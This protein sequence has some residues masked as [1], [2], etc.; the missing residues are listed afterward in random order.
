MASTPP[1][2]APQDT[3]PFVQARAKWDIRLN[4]RDLIDQKRYPNGNPRVISLRLTEKLGEEADELEIVI[5]DMLASE[6]IDPPP[7][8]S[9]LTVAIGWDRGSLVSTGMV[10]KGSFTV[11][12][13]SWGGPPDQITIT[14]RSAD[15]KDSFR[16]RKTRTWHDQTLGGVIGQLAADNALQPRCHPDL[17]GKP[18]TAAEQHN[19]SDMQFLR[20]LGRH[21]D[22]VATVKAGCLI[23]APRGAVTTASGKEIPGAVLFRSRCANV[24]WRRASRDKDQDGAEAQWHDS[25]AGKRKTVAKGGT[26]KKRLKRIYASEDDAS[27]A[28]QSE[29]N[30]QKR[31]SATLEATLAW[32]NPLLTPGMPIEAVGFRA[33]IDAQKWQIASTEHTMDASGFKSRLSMEVAG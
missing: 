1:A 4:G 9:I 5:H 19:K 29:M 22:A 27:T 11:D 32:G 18:I 6:P 33:H 14:A 16:T 17:A 7:Q 8:G 20:D 12:E 25:D 3:S 30:R 10:D 26:R 13:V 21:H 2:A 28:A 23:F 15:L 31:A 24:S